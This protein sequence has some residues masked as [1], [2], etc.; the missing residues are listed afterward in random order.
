MTTYIVIGVKVDTVKS[1]AVLK[2]GAEQFDPY[3]DWD[4]LQKALDEICVEEYEGARVVG[5]TEDWFYDK[6]LVLVLN[7]KREPFG[8]FTRMTSHQGSTLET[9]C[10][11]SGWLNAVIREYEVKQLLESSDAK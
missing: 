9:L 2:V 1:Q 5:T 6:V 3:T 4:V 10:K 8:K 7:M 11:V